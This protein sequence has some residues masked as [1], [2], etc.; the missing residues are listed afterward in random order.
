MVT[1]AYTWVKLS[2]RHL[3][4]ME[5][6]IPKTEYFRNLG[7]CRNAGSRVNFFSYSI[8]I[9]LLL[10]NLPQPLK[11]QVVCFFMLGL[12]PVSAL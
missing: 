12:C 8:T 10:L 4:S 3:L 5:N 11:F 1:C 6:F 9:A 2:F 7:A